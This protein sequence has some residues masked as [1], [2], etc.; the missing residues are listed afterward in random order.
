MQ[1]IKLI[2]AFPY[3]QC[4]LNDASIVGKDETVSDWGVDCYRPGYEV[5]SFIMREVRVELDRQACAACE[6]HE[7]TF[8]VK[9]FWG[10]RGDNKVA[11]LFE[12]TGGWNRELFL[13]SFYDGKTVMVKIHDRD[14][15]ALPRNIVRG[16]HAVKRAVDYWDTFGKSLPFVSNY[17]DN[18]SN[19]DRKAYKDPNRYA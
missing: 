14:L 12:T 1:G 19:V 18:W 3:E 13:M 11:Y 2:A 4:I 7:T 9:A 17:Q 10:D 6:S 8:G 5:P 15:A 16:R